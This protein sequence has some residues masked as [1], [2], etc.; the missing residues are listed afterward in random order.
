VIV[1][2]AQVKTGELYKAYVEWC[3]TNGEKSIDNNRHFGKQLS[4]RG[5]KPYRS[6]GVRYWRGI[7]SFFYST[8]GF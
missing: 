4:E 3:E 8:N 7:G 6:H 1:S 2:G 5:F